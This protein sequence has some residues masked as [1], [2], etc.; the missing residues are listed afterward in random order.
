MRI[1]L[2]HAVNFLSFASLEY[3]FKSGGR[4]VEGQNLTDDDQ[5]NNG[6]GKTAFQAAIEY[7]LYGT[8][9]LKVRDQN[10]VRFGHD[11][12]NLTLILYCPYRNERLKID[13][14]LRVK[15]SAKLEVFIN[16]LKINIATLADGN[17][18]IATWLA[19][20]KDDLQNYYIINK[21]RYRSFIRA[22]NTEKI[23]IISRFSNAKLIDE[24]LPNVEK[25]I[26]TH[27]KKHEKCHL[28]YSKQL[29]VVETLHNESPQLDEKDFHK[30]NAEKI[31]ELNKA[32]VEY[33]K[34]QVKCKDEVAQKEIDLKKVNIELISVQQAVKNA[35]A[36][37]EQIDN[38]PYRKETIAT[39]RKINALNL[40][41]SSDYQAK[42]ERQNDL[43]K[44][45]KVLAKVNLILMKQVTC[46]KC[47][48]VFNPSKKDCD[49]Q[50][51]KERGAKIERI[52]LILKNKIDALEQI[53]EQQ[54]QEI[55]HYNNK[56]STLA[57]AQ[58]QVIEKILNAK[59]NVAAVEDELM[60]LQSKMESVVFQQL[61]VNGQVNLYEDYIQTAQQSIEKHENMIYDKEVLVAHEKKLVKANSLQKK[62]LDEMNDQEDKLNEAK[63]WLVNLKSFKGY[64]ADKFLM[65]IESI[66]NE[67]LKNLKSDIQM[68]W[69]GYKLTSANVM[70]RKITPYI[71]R[72]GE[73]RDFNSFSGGERARVEFALILTIRQL[74]N[75]THTHGGLDFLF[76][77][78][79]FEGLDGKGLS[80]LMHSMVDFDFPI[81]ITTQLNNVNMYGK[82][83]KIVKDKG[84][85]TLHE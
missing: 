23:E 10:L 82:V 13:R 53:L 43:A 40:A 49:L 4:L 20:S 71:L 63:E 78:E 64:L 14:V 21:E 29:G 85:S 42:D 22:S 55:K 30:A 7:A 38:D 74:I 8:T 69:E 34:I 5:E 54:K 84:I 1:E 50:Q 45:E 57:Q 26:K 80:N 33:R 70:Q 77:D 75:S 61:K 28:A 62:L 72:N 37:L 48:H 39:E 56:K 15:S 24:V 73:T 3:I 17:A 60:T 31:S 59:K 18:F 65:V 2:L 46:P 6:S 32:I 76:A 16:E 9:S 68:K 47:Q 19:I 67:V 52:I 66:S 27:Q 81:L 36:V 11:Q 12:A 79:I 58:G 51:E 25:E 41:Y 35:Y 83:V 44:M